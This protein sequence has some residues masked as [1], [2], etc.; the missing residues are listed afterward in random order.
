[1]PGNL[2]TLIAAIAIVALVATLLMRAVKT[3][4]ATALKI[5]AIVLVLQLGFLIGPEAIW[6]QIREL[7]QLARDG[8]SELGPGWWQ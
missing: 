5:A 3:S 8:L 2:I 7:L 6:L 1:M 4:A